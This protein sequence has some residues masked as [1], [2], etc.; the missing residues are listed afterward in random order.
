MDAKTCLEKLSYVGTLSA[1]TVD[2]EGAPQLRCVS[3]IHYE[4]DALYFFTARGKSFC[5]ELERDGRVQLLGH[6]RFNEM[7][8]LTGKAIPAADQERWMDVIF[9]EQPYLANVYPGGTRSIG[10][11]F[12]I[13][14]MAMEYFNLG[15]RPIF[16][17]TYTVNGGKAVPKGFRI[18]DRCIGCGGC[19]SVCPQRA[20]EAGTPFRIRPENCLHC[21]ACFE[22]CPAQAVERL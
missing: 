22:R 5:R 10:I 6:T 21:G 3:A 2:A 4:P 8:R 19:R 1:A 15:V 18:T 13:R 9:A 14:D 7:I 16:R 20:I 17:E 12:E 11:I